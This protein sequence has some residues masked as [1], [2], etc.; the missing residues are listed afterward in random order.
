MRVTEY[1]SARAFLDA[2]L[3]LLLKNEPGNAILLSYANQQA[4]GVESA[5]STAFFSVDD[6]SGPV[7]PAMFTPNVVP[8]LSE[9]PEEAA[10]IM[11]RF[12]YPKH[13]HPN[14][15]N[16]PKDT[17]LAFADEWERLT[18]CDLEIQMDSRIYTC[19]DVTHP[20]NVSGQHRLAT[21]D[22][23][24]LVKKWRREFRSEADTIVRTSDEIIR[25]RIQNEQVHL[26]H[27]ESPVSMA[28]ATRS[29]G[30]LGMIGAV[31]TPPEHRNNGFASAVTA[32]A[33]ESILSSGKKYALLY[34]N[35]ANPTSNSIYQQIGFRP[36][37][38]TT[39]WRFN[40][41]I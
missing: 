20:E 4:E 32:V 3:H 15:V 11:A 8:L 37:M 22:D 27:T 21:L 41:S 5:M 19:E 12:F 17:T 1:E 18:R 25:E 10:R 30:N 35:L 36:V 34:T 26:W 16:G 31:Y 13:P 9:G 7:L 24:E 2:N 38:D 33:A 6:D 40:P 23:F 14:G 28:V 39:L 29:T